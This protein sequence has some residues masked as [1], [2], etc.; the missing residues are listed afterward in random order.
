M[1]RDATGQINLA[2]A[3]VG[4]REAVT[5][6]IAELAARKLLTRQP[7]LTLR[8]RQSGI[9]VLKAEGGRT[10]LLHT[11]EGPPREAAGKLGGRT[12]AE[13]RGDCALAFAAGLA[14]TSQMTLPA[15]SP[16]I[17]QA[18]VRN[19]VESMAPWPLSQTVFGLRVQPIAGDPAHVSVDVGIVSR[20]LLEDIAG[21]LSTAGS[22]V[23]AASVRLGEADAIRLDFGAEEELRDATRRAFRILKAY[24]AVAALIAAAG[25]FLAWQ[26]ATELWQDR[27]RTAALMASMRN[28]DAARTGTPLEAAA[29]GLQERRRLRPPAVAVLEERSTLLPQTVWLSSMALDDARL[30]LKRQGT[31]MPALIEIL[32][33][34]G[35]F[36]DVNFAAA[37]QLNEALNADAFSIGATLEQSAPAEA[38]Q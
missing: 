22:T 15:E 3:W 30:D 1:A 36:R 23:K 4:L 10:E 14:V 13:L 20:S 19:K 27:E 31:G 9:D 6:F 11:A 35:S 2:A 38:A 32:E 26:S 28:A 24:A 21:M 7:A 5:A 17:L 16:A 33:Q 25:L 34:S 29:N 18:I 12:G 37:T 8:I